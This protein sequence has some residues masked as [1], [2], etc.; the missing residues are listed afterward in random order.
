M[1]YFEIRA[2][3]V[4]NSAAGLLMQMTKLTMLSILQADHPK[5]ILIS[6]EGD[7]VDSLSLAMLYRWL[8]VPPSSCKAE[9]SCLGKK[10]HL[11]LKSSSWSTFMQAWNQDG[12]LQN[13]GNSCAW[14]CHVGYN[15]AIRGRWLPEQSRKPGTLEI[16][17]SKA[18]MEREM[19]VVVIDSLNFNWA[20]KILN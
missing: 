15:L 17:E 8:K 14:L 2:Q 18:K 13:I 7:L 4:Q 20:L 19:R 16:T 12:L 9:R 11:A 3:I 1:T 6:R 10:S 5:L